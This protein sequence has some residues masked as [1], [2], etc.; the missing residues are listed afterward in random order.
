MYRDVHESFGIQGQNVTEC[1]SLYPDLPQPPASC[2]HSVALGWWLDY[3][4]VILISWLGHGVHSEML[5]C[6]AWSEEVGHTRKGVP[7]S[8][9]ISGSWLLCLELLLLYDASLLCCSAIGPADYGLKFTNWPKINLQNKRRDS[10]SHLDYIDKLLVFFIATYNQFRA[11]NL[12]LYYSIKQRRFL[13][14]GWFQS[15]PNPFPLN[16]LWRQVMWLS[17]G[18]MSFCVLLRWH[19]EITSKLE[20]IA[21]I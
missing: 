5:R 16:S 12:L 7:L 14:K 10:T 18:Q 11:C 6:E 13:F 17:P 19:L 2:T 3:G 15:S 21:E 20:E 9:F 1:Y 8:R 4:S